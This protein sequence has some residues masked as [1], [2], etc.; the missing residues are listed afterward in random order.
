[1]FVLPVLSLLVVMPWLDVSIAIRPVTV[2]ANGMVPPVSMASF[3]SM[4]TIQPERFTEQPD[5]A[6][7]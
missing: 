4:E 2:I 1:M 3:P 6:G 7:S 5:I